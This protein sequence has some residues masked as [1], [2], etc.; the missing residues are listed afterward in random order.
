APSICFSPT[1]RSLFDEPLAIAVQGL[2]PQ[3]PVTLRMSLRDEMGELFQAWACYQAGDDGA[4]DLA[5]CPALP[6]GSFTGLE[7]MGLLWA[8]QPQ[9]PFWYMVKKDIQRPFL[10]QLEVFDGHRKPPG[11]LLAQ[12]QHERA[13]LQEGVQRVPV[14]EG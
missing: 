4:L 5:R 14:R 12:A 2:G 3:Q 9:K 6:G 8:L 7:P 10:V 13:F 11:R 1:A